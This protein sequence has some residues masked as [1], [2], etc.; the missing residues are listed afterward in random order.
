MGREDAKASPFPSSGL[1]AAPAS[2]TR[3]RFVLRRAVAM[4]D[5][6]GSYA[7]STPN[8]P[9]TAFAPTCQGGH[10]KFMRG[11]FGWINRFRNNNQIKNGALQSFMGR[12]SAFH[13]RSPVR[14]VGLAA[15]AVAANVRRRPP[16]ADLLLRSFDGSVSNS[17]TAGFGGGSAAPGDSWAAAPAWIDPVAAQGVH[18]HGRSTTGGNSR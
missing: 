2:I 11:A 14:G 15:G 17:A 16:Q 7:P 8:P 1:S 6:S 5:H 12:E 18:G 4:F 13:P 9:H 10:E 3:H